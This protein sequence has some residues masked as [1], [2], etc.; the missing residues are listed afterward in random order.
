MDIAAEITAL[1]ERRTAAIAAHDVDAVLEQVAP[2]IACFDLGGPLVQAGKSSLRNR[3][4]EWF[5][6]YDG[7]IGFLVR[8]LAIHGAG[9]VA[10]S[11][12]LVHISG[13]MT[14]GAAVSMWTRYTIGW[15]RQ[16]DRWLAIHEH[17]SDPM[18]FTTGMTRTD[19][20]PA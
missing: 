17:M 16:E 4:E 12:S 3:L 6:A 13:R 1:L 18:D 8:D 19:L 2:D 15:I 14:T 7:P 9:D 5:S 11:H 20:E 10:F